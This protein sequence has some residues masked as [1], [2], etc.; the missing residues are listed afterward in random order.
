MDNISFSGLRGK[1]LVHTMTGGMRPIRQAVI[2][3]GSNLGERL[4]RLQG[5]VAAIEDTALG[6]ASVYRSI[7]KQRFEKDPE[8]FADPKLLPQLPKK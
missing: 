7:A 2:A 4:Q 5:G 1:G 3:L 8:R 6:L